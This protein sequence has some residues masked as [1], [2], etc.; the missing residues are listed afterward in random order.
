MNRI[1]QDSYRLSRLANLVESGVFAVPQLQR[2]FVWNARKS[3]D[4]LDSIYRNYPIGTLLVWK[5]NRRNEGQLRK[6]LH[7][8]PAYDASN[9]DIYFLV[10]GQQRLSVLWH[11]LRGE[12][13]Q[14]T[15]SDG[16]TI[17]FGKVYFNIW[18]EDG[19]PWFVY[20]ARLADKDQAGLASVVDILSPRWRQRLRAHGPRN[21]ARVKECRERILAYEAL[22]VFC[23]TNELSE[24]RETFIRVNSLGMRISSADR[25]F[26]RASSFDL[27]HDVRD[28]L[29]RLQ[30]GFDGLSR[31][32][33]LQTISFAL[34]G[35][36]LGERAFDTMINRLENDERARTEYDRNWRHLREAFGQAA[37]YFVHELGVPN[38]EFLPSEPMMV[39]LALYF[40]HNGNVRPPVAAK[41]TL[42]SW[43]WATAVGER[44]SGR[45]YRTN[46]VSDAKFMV[47][48]AGN[49]GIRPSFHVSTPRYVLK[50]TE[51]SR[52]GPR[53]NAFFILLR[54]QRPR[55]L[56]DGSEIPLGEI[57]SRRNRSDKHHIFPRALLLNAGIGAARF[58]SILNICYLVARENQR[59]GQRSP[60][61][62]LTDLPNSKRAMRLA[63][64]SHLL[65]DAPTSGLWSRST[66]Q[67]F[68][69]FLDQRALL[70]IAA[71]EAEA[72]MKLFERSGT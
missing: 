53:S 12:A 72:G 50:A 54:R 29:H 5:T 33:V 15:N 57:S 44:Y 16:K 39:I 70:L 65:P 51:Y 7:I 59:V 20:R 63:M 2:E 24:V 14:V 31:E 4:L 3:C 61:Y 45:G 22:V 42:K 41:R 28:A 43:F 23:E 58:N 17:D 9:R 55:Y 30:H 32:T 37:D 56:E 47:R 36:D 35:Q 19:Q 60:R 8:L 25:A 1:Y 10:D 64:R 69:T 38:L 11:F 52:P 49:A 46:I 48:L 26:A 62:Y 66:K 18:A 71:F 68:N 67:G 27:R 34:G 40:F 6:T 13:H 21:F